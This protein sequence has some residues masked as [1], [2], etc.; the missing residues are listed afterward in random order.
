MKDKFGGK[1][2]RFCLKASV[3]LLP[4]VSKNP[5]SILN[6]LFDY[7]PKQSEKNKKQYH[8]NSSLQRNHPVNNYWAVVFIR[9]LAGTAD[10]KVITSSAF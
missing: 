6:M 1:I 10:Q 2:I 4:A 7:K 9:H 5:R 8:V 3:V